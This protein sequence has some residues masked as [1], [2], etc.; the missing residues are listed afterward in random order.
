MIATGLAVAGC[1]ALQGSPAAQGSASIHGATSAAGVSGSHP[2]RA[3]ASPAPRAGN[4][5]LPVL[6]SRQVAD[7][8][9]LPQKWT[10]LRLAQGG[11]A[12]EI[13]YDFGGCLATP[14]GVLVSQSS[15][16]VTMSLEAPSP[17]LAADC[18][19]VVAVQVAWVHLP[20]LGGRT[21]QH[22]LVDN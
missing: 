19:P 16:T 22:A 10:L 15:T 21:L 3:T 18:A 20:A 6:T 4:L 12:A 5:W 1:G 9:L 17:P 11:T 13:S 8:H 14:K 7:G 2:A